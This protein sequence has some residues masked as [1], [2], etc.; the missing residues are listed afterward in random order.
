MPVGVTT[1]EAID[2]EKAMRIASVEHVELRNI[3]ELSV[4][5]QVLKCARQMN[6]SGGLS[7]CRA[8]GWNI[9]SHS[10]LMAARRLAREDSLLHVDCDDQGGRRTRNLPCDFERAGE[11]CQNPC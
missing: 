8:V 3:M 6:F 11:K 2:R 10:R 4:M 9:R 5:G 1:Q 7:L